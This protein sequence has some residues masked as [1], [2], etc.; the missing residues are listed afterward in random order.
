M[1]FSSDGGQ[2]VYH[3]TIISDVT[4]NDIKFCAHTTG[5]KDKKL[6][7]VLGNETVV[8]VRLNDRI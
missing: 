8:I 1:Y 6:S 7:E 2:T 5:R 3:A 4:N